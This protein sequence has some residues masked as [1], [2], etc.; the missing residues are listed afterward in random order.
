MILSNIWYEEEQEQIQ[1]KTTKPR[2]KEICKECGSE[3]ENIDA[4]SCP[5]C[6]ANLCKNG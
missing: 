5:Y 1:I 6:G 3:I 4:I 2:K